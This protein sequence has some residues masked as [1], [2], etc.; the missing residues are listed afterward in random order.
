MTPEKTGITNSLF[1]L[2]KRAA[3]ADPKS[4]MGWNDLGLAYLDSMQD[5]LAI[6]AF[7]KQIEV[8]SYHQYAYNNLGRVYLRQRK[9][10]EA[11]KWFNK[12]IEIDPLDKYAH[13]YLGISYLELHKYGDAAPE[14]EKAASLT[15][16]NAEAYVRLGNAYLNLDQDQKAMAAFDKAVKLSARPLTWNDIA[17]YLTLKRAHLD[18]ARRYAESAVSSTAALLRTLSLDQLQARD[19][20]LTATLANSW[21]TLAWVEFADGNVDKAQK[22]ALA[23]WQ[24]GQHSA[25]ADHLGQIYEKRGEKEN[26]LHYYALAMNARRPEAETRSRLEA[27]AGESSS[28]DSLIEKNREELTGL[29]TVKVN[30]PSKQ[31]GKAEFFVLLALGPGSDVSVDSVKLITGEEKLKGCADALRTAR[32]VQT[33][34]DDT[35]VK[36]LRRGT[37]S[38][39]AAADCTFVLTLPNEVTSVD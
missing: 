23:A 35:A 10:D 38:C 11:M 18:L 17:Y 2:L 25:A 4:K 16:D 13:R 32:F 34:P 33:M 22:Y 14:L 5:E 36:L 39:A 26:A 15:P 12:Q 3:E 8:N 1:D 28:A 30:N 9:Y 24:L 31:E 7:Q 6:T 37:L 19:L 21:D 27:L 29:R 20:G